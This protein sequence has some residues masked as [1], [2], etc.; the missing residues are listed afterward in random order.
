ML[1]VRRRFDFFF[2]FFIA[3]VPSSPDIQRV[4]PFS[5]TAVV[6]FEEPD[7]SGGVPIIKYRVEWRSSGQKWVGRE[8]EAEEGGS[9]FLLWYLYR[10]IC[11]Q[12]IELVTV[13]VTESDILTFFCHNV[14]NATSEILNQAKNIL[15]KR[16]FRL[17]PQS[18]TRGRLTFIKSVSCHAPVREKC[19]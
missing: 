6:V 16:F 4:E 7:S 1:R 18:A 2:S 8:Y 13:T 5:S 17:V 11:G 3:E 9:H 10:T 14:R 12:T 15:H 19:M